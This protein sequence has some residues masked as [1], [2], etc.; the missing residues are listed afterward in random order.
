M[1][2]GISSLQTRLTSRCPW[3]H[4]GTG[5]TSTGTCRGALPARPDSSILARGFSQVKAA[6]RE[7]APPPSP[8]LENT[9]ARIKPKANRQRAV[10][11]K[12][13]KRK[14]GAPPKPLVSP[15]MRFYS[16]A[17]HRPGKSAHGSRGETARPPFRAFISELPSC[18]ISFFRPSRQD[19]IIS[20][21]PQISR[22]RLV[23]R[24]PLLADPPFR[25]TT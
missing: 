8:Q 16:L 9:H 3:V 23:L 7:F 22:G 18:H 11:G 20:T 15:P 17:Q 6:I 25:R 5:G 12:K 24:L 1:R 2:R 21:S 14:K 10:H 13:R 19:A 4:A